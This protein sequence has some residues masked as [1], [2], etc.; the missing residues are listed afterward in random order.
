MSS[1]G[2]RGEG[3]GS[4]RRAGAQIAWS[5]LRLTPGPREDLTGDGKRQACP[6]WRVRATSKGLR[7]GTLGM[8]PEPGI[9][10]VWVLLWGFGRAGTRGLEAKSEVN[11]IKGVWD[12]KRKG[13]GAWGISTGVQ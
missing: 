11:R 10:D 1:A 8:P 13:E 5:V 12:S 9:L 3:G 7:P 4:G 2:S 6:G